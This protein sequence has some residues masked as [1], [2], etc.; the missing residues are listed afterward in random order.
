MKVLMII[1][2]A[3]QSRR[4]PPNKLLIPIGGETVIEKT[5]ST[6]VG[7]P[8]DVLVVT[9]YEQEKIMAVLTPRF[10]KQ[11]K[12]CHNEDF[13]SG[14]SSSVRAGIQAG[15]DR[16]DYY[17]FCN[18][19]KPFISP[20]TVKTLLHRLDVS[21]PLILLPKVGETPGHPSFFHRSL[22]DELLTLD[23]DSGGR[24]LIRK[25]AKDT[26]YVS[27]EDKGVITDMDQTLEK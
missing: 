13:A 3:G 20:E 2:A 16:Y 25:Y 14:L 12:F 17:G 23:G 18:G 8:T 10:E 4:H 22:R 6:F 5:V 24:P 27:V 21:Q 26:E 9:G 15:G 19:D 1:T 7:L 11:V